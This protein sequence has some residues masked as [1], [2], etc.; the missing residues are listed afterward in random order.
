MAWGDAGIVGVQ[1][2]EASV[3]QTRARMRS[4]FPNAREL[5]PPPR[6]RE[7][8]ADMAALLGGERRDLSG[9]VLDME[10]VPPFHRR[11]YLAARKI[12]AGS[13]IE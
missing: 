1:L 11:V 8:I 2:P 9:I 3:Q 13:T 5:A 12:A 7:A 10:R 4:R 6:V